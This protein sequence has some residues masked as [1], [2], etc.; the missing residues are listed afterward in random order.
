MTL[1]KERSIEI[2]FPALSQMA[3][4]G[5]GTAVLYLF[6]AMQST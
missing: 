3:R 2:K 6:F 5:L 4:E 1:A